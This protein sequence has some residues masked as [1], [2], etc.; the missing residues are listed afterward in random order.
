VRAGGAARRD[1][2]GGARPGTG[3]GEASHRRH[4]QLAGGAKEQEKHMGAARLLTGA[5]RRGFT[6]TNAPYGSRASGA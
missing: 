3:R 2:T 4:A 1:C 5:I 6:A